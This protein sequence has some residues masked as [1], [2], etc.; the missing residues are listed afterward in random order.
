MLG[1]LLSVCVPVNGKHRQLHI[2]PAVAL[3][4]PDL[5]DPLHSETI[6][7]VCLFVY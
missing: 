2:E 3:F 6:L 5:Y 1:V 7:F 4:E